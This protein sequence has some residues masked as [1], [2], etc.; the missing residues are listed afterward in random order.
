[1]E[2]FKYPENTPNAGETVLIK[3]TEES[4]NWSG[5][6]YYVCNVMKN[7]DYNPNE[8]DYYGKSEYI[9]EEAGGEQYC[10][11]SSNEVEAWMPL[12]ML[13][14]IPVSLCRIYRPKES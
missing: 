13:D 1:M 4:A 8:E 7:D 12:N 3:T 5:F 6:K 11:W 14:E 2:F 9:F 10:C